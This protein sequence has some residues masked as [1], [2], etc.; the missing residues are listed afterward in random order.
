MEEEGDIG[1]VSSNGGH[2]VRRRN[3]KKMLRPKLYFLNSEDATDLAIES[4][5][6][7]TTGLLLGNERK[8]IRNMFYVY[9]HK[10]NQQRQMYTILIPHEFSTCSTSSL[11]HMTITFS[12]SQRIISYFKSFW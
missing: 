9:L 4:P 8:V 5:E 7:I 2:S 6:V 12:F 11:S 3:S 1:S 10:W